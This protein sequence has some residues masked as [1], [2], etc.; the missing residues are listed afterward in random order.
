MVTGWRA[1]PATGA[2]SRT[3]LSVSGYQ[4][5][6]LEN[7]PTTENSSIFSTAYRFNCGL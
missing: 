2:M 3:K 6:V 4:Q 1:M 5:K 7:S